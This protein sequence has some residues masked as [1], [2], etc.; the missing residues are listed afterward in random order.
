[1][2][3][4]PSSEKLYLKAK[5]IISSGCSTPVFDIYQENRGLV[6][7]KSAKGSR[8]TDIDNNEYIDF[9]C[10]YGALILG[11]AEDT[12]VAAIIDQVTK[13]TLY[14][15]PTE[16]EFKL[17]QLIVDSSEFIDQVRFTCSGTEA[18]MT[19]LRLAKYYTNR[20]KVVRFHGLYHGH[21]DVVLGRL[22]KEAKEGQFGIDAAIFNNTIMAHYNNPAEVA[23]IFKQHGDEIAAVLVEPIACNGGL[24]LPK[25]EFLAMLRSLCTAHGAL[26]IYDEVITGFRVNFGSV[27]NPMDIP[28]D[29]ITFGKVIGGGTPIGAYAGKR[30]I[31]KFHDSEQD[32]LHFS[33]TF[34]A[35]PLTMAAAVAVLTELSHGQVYKRL[36]QLGDYLAQQIKDKLSPYHDHFKFSYLGSIFSLRLM[37][38]GMDYDLAYQDYSNLQKRLM[39]RGILMTPSPDETMYISTAHTTEDIDELV[40]SLRTEF[41]LMFQPIPGE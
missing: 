14:C 29:L 3:Y 4:S 17:S 31:M 35:N 13:G 21:A 27:T 9:I 15:L 23:K 5:E 16:L 1:M 7:I 24:A 25:Y 33:G 28:P 37:K 10:G 2:N 18:V 12:I 20:T 36:E 32:N 38:N 34:A 40:E 11:H 26:L 30:E 39:R 6:Y 22:F 19:A 8:I 41:S